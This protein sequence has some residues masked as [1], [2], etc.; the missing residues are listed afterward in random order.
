MGDVLRRERGLR[1]GA[2]MGDAIAQ[3]TSRDGAEYGTSWP[4]RLFE[5]SAASADV[6]A[7]EERA[8][9]VKAW[10]VERE[11]PLREVFGPRADEVVQ[12]VEGVERTGWLRPG[13]AAEARLPELVAQHYAALADY[14]R[15]P[16]P[17]P[18]RVV[19]TWHEARDVHDTLDP[20]PAAATAAIHAGCTV[21]GS[22]IEEIATQLAWANSSAN[23]AFVQSTV[24]PVPSRSPPRRAPSPA[25]PGAT[26][27]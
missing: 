24:P 10:R 9:R 2:T 4:L 6:L 16:A 21:R 20:K 15:A 25:A 5:G 26:A 1:V 8:M 7:T 14:G 27:A 22:I 13:R 23:R 12:L 18:V 11:V 17:P 19:R 3:W